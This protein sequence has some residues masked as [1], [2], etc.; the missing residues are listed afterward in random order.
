MKLRDLFHFVIEQGIARDPRGAESV[1]QSLSEEK[2]RYDRL[3]A[4]EKEDFDPEKLSNPYADSRIL[5]GNGDEEITSVMAGIDIE[6]PELLLCE[7]LRARGR[8]IDLVMTHHPEGKAYA[9]FYQVMGMQAEIINRLGVPINIA[10]AMTETRMRE[11]GRKVMPQNHHRSVDAARLL[12]IPFMSA[13]TAADN[14]VSSY[15]QSFLDEKQPKYL[16][17]VLKLLK[18]IPEYRFAAQNGTGPVI[19]TG[20]KDNRAG[21][22]FVDMTGG[23]EGAK[24]VL[25]KLA[26]SGVGTIVGMHMSD[27]HYKNAEKFH[28]RVVIAGHISSDNLGVNLLFDAIEKKFGALTIIESS[29]FKRFRHN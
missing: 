13:H 19:L 3:T 7:S 28:L 14:Q 4:E 2:S 17:D 27:E 22:I 10:E 26:D 29:G 23:T 20:G 25:E 5:F 24:D 18:D 12:G 15:L 1:R 8:S 11:V 16:G 21:R 9:T 6:T